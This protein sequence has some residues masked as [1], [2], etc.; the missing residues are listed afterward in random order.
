MNVGASIHQEIVTQ[1]CTLYLHVQFLP[2]KTYF[3]D[4]S[5]VLFPN[6][7]NHRLLRPETGQRSYQP[8]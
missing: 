2:L 6:N 5:G 3:T 1:R 4:V 7:T 8:F